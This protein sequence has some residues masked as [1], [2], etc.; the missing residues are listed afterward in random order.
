[1]YI[2]ENT[3][4]HKTKLREKR[5]G[6]QIANLSYNQIA[7]LSYKWCNTVL[8]AGNEIRTVHFYGGRDFRN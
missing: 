3:V 5:L 1:M 8:R 4:K 7:N 2:F 6:N